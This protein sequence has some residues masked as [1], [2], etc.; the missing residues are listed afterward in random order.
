MSETDFLGKKITIRQAV[1]IWSGNSSFR[2][3]WTCLLYLILLYPATTLISPIDDYISF[4]R[5]NCSKGGWN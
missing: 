2:H 1:I 4:K 5:I 3:G